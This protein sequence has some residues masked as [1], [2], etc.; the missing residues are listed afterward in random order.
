MILVE[1]DLS[2]GGDGVKIQQNVLISIRLLHGRRRDIVETRNV[3]Q[4][5]R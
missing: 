1:N 4:V 2:A 5:P 3:L